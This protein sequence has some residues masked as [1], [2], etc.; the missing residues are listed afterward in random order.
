MALDGIQP[1][2]LALWEFLEMFEIENIGRGV[3]EELCLNY[4]LEDESLELCRYERWYEERQFQHHCEVFC[5]PPP[6]RQTRKRKKPC[7][8]CNVFGKG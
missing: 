7:K 1:Q 5:P 6:R 2:M 8:K 3:L 4:H